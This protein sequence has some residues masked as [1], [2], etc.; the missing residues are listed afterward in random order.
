[1]RLFFDTSA[2]VKRYFNERGSDDV[3]SLCAMA[4]DVAVSAVLPVEIISTLA[5]LKRERRIDAISFNQIK[6]AF[7]SDLADMTV[8]LL[9]PQVISH[10]FAAVEAMPLKALDALHI[11][12]ALEYKPD[13]FVSGDKQQIFAAKSVGLH[14]EQSAM[15]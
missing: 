14:V 12:C 7:F 15:E 10:A 3:M 5:R 1:V 13:L 11:G 6:N 2:L 4:D 8:I 9:S